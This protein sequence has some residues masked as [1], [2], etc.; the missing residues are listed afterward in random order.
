[1]KKKALLDLECID[2]VVRVV[3]VVVVV[4]VFIV[5]VFGCS[6]GKMDT[7]FAGFIFFFLYRARREVGAHFTSFRSFMSR[8]SG[9]NNRAK[10]VSVSIACSVYQD[11]N[12][13]HIVL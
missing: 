11:A 1:M 5:V 4:M 2:G 13:A 12:K 7:V 8:A 9:E 6:V 10:S 3:V